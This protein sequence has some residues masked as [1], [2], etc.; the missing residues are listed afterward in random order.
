MVSVTLPNSTSDEIQSGDIVTT[1]S[2]A[3]TIP[4]E[5][6]PRQV[7]NFETHYISDHRQ[8]SPD[9]AGNTLYRG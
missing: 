4:I 3:V 7:T 5:V 6:D 8:L 2:A 9:D 1:T